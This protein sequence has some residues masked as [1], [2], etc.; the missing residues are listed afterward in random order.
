[1]ISRWHDHV[2]WMA[3]PAPPSSWDTGVPALAGL[4]HDVTGHAQIKPAEDHGTADLKQR[5]SMI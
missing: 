3:S 1:M 2:C 5:S 4:N